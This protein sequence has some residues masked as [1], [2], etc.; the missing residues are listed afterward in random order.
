[1][2]FQFQS[3]NCSDGGNK[4]VKLG[5]QRR[6]SF[7]SKLTPLRTINHPDYL[8]ASLIH[9]ISLIELVDPLVLSSTVGI[10]KLPSADSILPLGTDLMV[11]GWG[12]TSKLIRF[13]SC[14]EARLLVISPLTTAMRKFFANIY[15]FV[16][17][18][19]KVKNIK[20]MKFERNLTAISFTVLLH[21]RGHDMGY[22]LFNYRHQQTRV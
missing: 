1:M 19:F 18:L 13:L 2:S 10:M 22:T 4:L 17:E 11:T 16:H 12:Y 8:R 6:G 9:D 21:V 7:S 5:S 3:I 14:K 15:L 20:S